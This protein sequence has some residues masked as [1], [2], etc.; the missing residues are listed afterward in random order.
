MNYQAAVNISAEYTGQKQIQQASKDLGSLEGNVKSVVGGLKALAGA[1]AVKEA[2]TFL[3][4]VIDLGDHMQE[5]RSKTGIQVQTLSDLA[6]VAEDNGVQ[7]EQFESALK[8]FTV[9]IGKASGGNREAAGGFNALGISMKNSSGQMK[10]ADELLF[11]VADKFSMAKD[12]SAKAA[13]AVALF[14]KTGA[15]LIPLLNEGRKS[16]EGM[17]VQLSDKFVHQADVFNDNLNKLKRSSQQFGASILE[18]VLPPVNTLLEKFLEFKKSGALGKVIDHFVLPGGISVGGLKT[19]MKGDIFGW[20]DQ[21]GLNAPSHADLLRSS[22]TVPGKTGKIDTSKLAADRQKETDALK[23]QIAVR[24]ELVKLNVLEVQK[25]E[26]STAEYDKRKI[27]LEE[28]LK[29]DKEVVGFS[30]KGKAAYKAVTDEIVAQ[31]QALIDLQEQQKSSFG[32]GLDQGWK[33]YV[34]SA[35]DV[36][37]QSKQAFGNAFGA[38]EDSFVSFV[39]TGQLS[40]R[41]LADSIISDLARI[42]F[43]QALVFG[44]SSLFS[45]GASAGGGGAGLFAGK[46]VGSTMAPFANGGIMTARGKLQSY[47]NGGI[48]NS[49]QLAMFGEGSTPEAFVPLPDGKRIPVHMR[50]SAGGDVHVTVNS[51]GPTNTSGTNDQTRKL[52]KLIGDTVKGVLVQ[53]K[54]PGGLLFG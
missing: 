40:F 29:A 50:G 53:E 4:S 42:A 25:T 3:K 23:K 43:R 20:G 8:K 47:A 27:A 31:K 30:S 11:E 46:G 9:T 44:I 48:A 49:P 5:L 17:G 45:A 52:G 16:I 2:A 26:L 12:G 15:D 54:R 19:L 1:W 13:V 41:N 36:A 14:G 51:D 10:T 37:A 22:D 6:A 24:D 33:A 21:L 18:D 28:N 39:K 38:M 34:E 35:K 7:F 32:H